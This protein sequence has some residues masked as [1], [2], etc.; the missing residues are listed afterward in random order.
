[1]QDKERQQTSGEQDKQTTQELPA[2]KENGKQEQPFI[3]AKNL[4]VKTV[5][6]RVFENVSFTAEKGQVVALFGADGSGK[7][8]LL[9]T[10]GGRMKP[11]SGEA[12]I[13]GFD[14]IHEYKRVRDLSGVSLIKNVNDIPEYLTVYD[15][16]ASDL[17]LNSRKCNKAA[18]TKYLDDWG[19]TS[20]AKKRLEEL[21]PNE[22][23]ELDLML[24]CTD[25]PTLLLLDEMGKGMTYRRTAQLV[26]HLGIFAREYGVC[27]LFSTHEYDIARMADSVVVLSSAAE[28]QRLR[29]IRDQGEVAKCTVAGSGNGVKCREFLDA[30]PKVVPPVGEKKT[31]L[32]ELFTE[33]AL[34]V[35]FDKMTKNPADNQPSN[36]QTKEVQ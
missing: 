24:A 28:D 21:N 9:L 35:H 34:S 23:M 20:C 16:L 17:A 36:S 22:K 33:E 1:M 19:F 29:V 18:V 26:K 10:L 5:Q 12:K 4:S 7:T 15:N 13:G 2:V 25:E 32:S 30:P 6:G 27:V 8:S 11:T 14:L 31:P 3:C